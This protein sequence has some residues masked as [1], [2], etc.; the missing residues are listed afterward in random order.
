MGKDYHQINNSS[1]VVKNIHLNIKPGQII[2]KQDQEGIKDLTK[3][4][5]DKSFTILGEM[6]K[7]GLI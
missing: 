6:E 1:Y 2:T 3:T 5:I 4:L 7:Q